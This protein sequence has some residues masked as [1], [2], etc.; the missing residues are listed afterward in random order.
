MDPPVQDIRMLLP[1]P[2][3]DA[4]VET[5]LLLKGY[6]TSRSFEGRTFRLIEPLLAMRVVQYTA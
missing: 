6:T 1:G 4:F 2:L 3:E 5:D